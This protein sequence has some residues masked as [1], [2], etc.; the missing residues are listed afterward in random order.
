LD[1]VTAF[2]SP[3]IDNTNISMFWPAGYPEGLNAPKIIIRLREALNGLKQPPW[4]RDD[5]INAFVLPVQFT[6]SLAYPKL[7]LRSNV[8]LILWYVDDISIMGV[9]TLSDNILLLGFIP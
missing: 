1:V 4:M 3:E 9:Y 5:N 8:M 2:L 7:N 6:Q